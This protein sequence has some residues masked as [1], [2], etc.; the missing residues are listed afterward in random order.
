MSFTRAHPFPTH[1]CH[2]YPLNAYLFLNHYFVNQ[3]H[4]VDLCLLTRTLR[5][6][7]TFFTIVQSCQI[8]A[9]CIGVKPSCQSNLNSVK[10][11]RSAISR[12]AIPGR[13]KICSK[14]LL[15]PPPFETAFSRRTLAAES[16]PSST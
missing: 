3:T 4:T 6:C 16:I 7:A 8:S 14:V 15:R 10:M 9:Y 2:Q 12:S 1:F 11:D 5:S 13:W